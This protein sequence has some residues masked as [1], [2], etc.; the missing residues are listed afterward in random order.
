MGSA[1]LARRHKIGMYFLNL[2]R[3]KIS[4]QIDQKELERLTSR[5]RDEQ[6][7]LGIGASPERP[8]RTA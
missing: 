2:V 5:K 6:L 7:S 3:M 4:G 1:G 8:G